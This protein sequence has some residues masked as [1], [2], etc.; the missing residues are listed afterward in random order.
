[1]DHTYVPDQKP[2]PFSILL[3]CAGFTSSF[4]LRLLVEASNLIIRKT[5]MYNIYTCH[6]S[7]YPKIYPSTAYL[8]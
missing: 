1:M 7:V 8:M 2:K 6:L 4:K 5:Y 3:Q